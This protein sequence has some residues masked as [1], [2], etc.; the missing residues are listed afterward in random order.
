MKKI[1][2]SLMLIAVV[3]GVMGAAS[4]AGMGFSGVGALSL[5]I[6][7]VDT[8]D[9]DYLGFHLNSALYAPVIVDGVY[10]SLDKDISPDNAVSVSVRDS[11]GNE[12]AYYAHNDVTW[13]AADTILVPLTADGGDLPS[14]KAVCKVKVV[15]AT[16]SHYN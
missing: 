11:T 3:V 12:L 16:N 9:V 1:L 14:A 5:G 15:V 4:T 6:T 8:V 13:A 10:I 7:D 2:V